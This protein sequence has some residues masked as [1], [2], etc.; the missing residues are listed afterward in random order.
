MGVKMKKISFMF[1]VVLLGSS[2]FAH[3]EDNSALVSCLQSNIQLLKENNASYYVATVSG[4]SANGQEES[5]LKPMVKKNCEMAKGVL[6]STVT[7]TDADN[8]HAI[9]SGV[10]KR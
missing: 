6:I 3:A 5:L 9:C 4:W 8:Y 7:C 1:L 2:M 10:C